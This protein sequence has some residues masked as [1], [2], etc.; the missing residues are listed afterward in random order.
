MKMKKR[1]KYVPSVTHYFLSDMACQEK[2]RLTKRRA[3]NHFLFH[4][5]N[6]LLTFKK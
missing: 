4:F 3:V 1:R 6:R 2:E 5:K